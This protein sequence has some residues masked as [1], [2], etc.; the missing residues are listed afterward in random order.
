MYMNT[1]LSIFLIAGLFMPA[2]LQ[3]NL[4][5]PYQLMSTVNIVSCTP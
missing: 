1:S 4:D 5:V 3:A 2:N